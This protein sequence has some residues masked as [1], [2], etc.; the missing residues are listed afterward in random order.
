MKRHS[1]SNAIRTGRRRYGRWRNSAS[2][3]EVYV[4]DAG[5]MHTLAE[6]AIASQGAD[7][8][9]AHNRVIPV[10]GNCT[11]R[12]NDCFIFA[13]DQRYRR[14]TILRCQVGHTR[15]G[16]KAECRAIDSNSW[17]RRWPRHAAHTGSPPNKQNPRPPSTEFGTVRKKQ[18][19]NGPATL[20]RSTA[21]QRTKQSSK[22]T[23]DHHI[24]SHSH[25]FFRATPIPNNHS[26]RRQSRPTG[27]PAPTTN[28]TNG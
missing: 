11:E 27:K 4:G 5:L 8:S 9:N 17:P 24:D 22:Q 12:G 13:G 2:V 15:T 26:N 28:P 21:G 3:A 1:K 6:S 10:G 16:N 20:N 18:L 7:M 19:D 25:P 14:E 23:A